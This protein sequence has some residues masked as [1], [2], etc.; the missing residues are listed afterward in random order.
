M[1]VEDNRFQTNK[2][3]LRNIVTIAKRAMTILVANVDSNTIAK[4]NTAEDYKKY[5]EYMNTISTTH[6]RNKFNLV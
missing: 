2:N 5:N 6:L 3:R 4:P 1:I